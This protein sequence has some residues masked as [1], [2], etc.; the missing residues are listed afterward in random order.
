MH[1]NNYNYNTSRK[2][3]ILPE[4]GRHIHE[5]VD[6]IIAMETKE[7]RNR[8]AR[9]II[10]VMGSLFPH[11]RDVPDFKHKLWDHLAII[12]EFK[13]DIDWPYPLPTPET[14]AEKPRKVPYEQGGI[15]YKHYGKLLESIIKKAS[16]MDD[17]AE[18]EVL[19][20]IIANLLKKHYLTWN[21]EAVNDQTIFNDLREISKGK[22]NI[23]LEQVRLSETRDIL[24]NKNKSKS[25][26]NNQKN[27]GK[28]RMNNMKKR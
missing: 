2:R 4:Y 8:A 22:I 10:N 6:M 13:L 24:N 16:T 12:S 3:L 14:L 15:K 5:M 11:L 23:G 18:K 1:T 7:E 25:R 17:N 27:K 19:L 28:M 21:R 26:M 20:S 9:G